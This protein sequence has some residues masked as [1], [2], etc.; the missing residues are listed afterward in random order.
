MKD[1]IKALEIFLK[2]S[3]EK[4]PTY[5]EHDVLYVNVEPGN[6]S[7]SDLSELYDLG[8]FPNEDGEG[9]MSFRYGS[10]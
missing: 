4:Y 5:C 7:D 2:Y 9:F 1:L 6:V 8:F 10:C 3:D